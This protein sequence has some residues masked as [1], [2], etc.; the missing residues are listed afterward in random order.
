MNSYKYI[1]VGSGPGACGFIN[2]I[3]QRDPTASL[4]LLEHGSD[5]IEFDE[6]KY[7]DTQGL[8]LAN[9]E[10]LVESDTIEQVYCNNK[11]KQILTPKI[12][13]GGGECN[14]S[15]VIKG[16]KYIYDE[17]WPD[18]FNFT[19][20]TKYLNILICN[21]FVAEPS[22]D[23]NISDSI[24]IKSRRGES[25]SFVSRETSSHFDD[26]ELIGVFGKNRNNVKK[27]K[28]NFE[29]DGRR[30]TLYNTLVR[31][32]YD[33]SYSVGNTLSVSSKYKKIDVITDFKVTRIL[34]E[35]NDSNE[36]TRPLKPIGV[37]GYYAN[38]IN[39]LIEFKSDKYI[40]IGAG[41]LGS[42]EL[43]VNSGIGPRN[44]LVSSNIEPLIDNKNVGFNLSDQPS[45]QNVYRMQDDT[46]QRDLNKNHNIIYRFLLNT[47]C[48]RTSRSYSFLYALFVYTAY[49]FFS[50]LYSTTTY[51][52]AQVLPTQS[53]NNNVA[54]T[55]T[56]TT[57]VSFTYKLSVFTPV[58]ILYYFL[59][60]LILLCVPTS[61]DTSVLISLIVFCLDIIVLPLIQNNKLN[62]FFTFEILLILSGI[63]FK[64]FINSIFRYL[65]SKYVFGQSI[66]NA[67]TPAFSMQY[68]TKRAQLYLGYLGTGYFP[69]VP[70]LLVYLPKSKELQ[71]IL[72]IILYYFII[73]FNPAKWIFERLWV[74]ISTSRIPKSKG[75]YVYL[76]SKWKLDPNYFSDLSDLY[77]IIEGQKLSCSLMDSLASY[78]IYPPN[79][80]D[81]KGFSSS[82][83]D[84]IK[85]NCKT[86]YHLTGTCRMASSTQQNCEEN[87]V[88]D[89]ENNLNVFGTN[90]VIVVGSPVFPT[91]I[92][93]SNSITC[94][95]TGY[96]SA[97]KIKI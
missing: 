40:I 57:V 76:N 63:P 4:L 28:D 46:R 32:L 60:T 33:D 95:W 36:Y 14:G 87:A 58:S 82:N 78:R 15:V 17:E 19:S 92:D 67:E 97:S 71:N 81:I 96:V 86:T 12:L 84:F 41:A 91:P 5:S 42:V 22:V 16:S 8:N 61:F 64:I 59:N 94:A 35:K 1:V 23:T 88:V 90:G 10:Y 31:P 11:K 79:R 47:V 18:N 37:I 50:C 2:E 39:R 89:Y 55:T 53:I 38:D 75:S 24:N 30:I 77:D 6:T 83:V 72:R 29:H 80:I 62:G 48:L 26:G 54:N 7:I 85:D 73:I 51:V 66:K 13:G 49:I 74:V 70:R 34:F 9:T 21:G 68:F 44:Y 20:V 43:L 25:Q 65:K 52:S 56:S 69:A 3:K 45:V 27:Y 93:T